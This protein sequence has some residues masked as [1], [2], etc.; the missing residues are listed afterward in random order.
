MNER[1]AEWTFIFTRWIGSRPATSRQRTRLTFSNQNGYSWTNYNP[2][3]NVKIVTRSPV[4]ETRGESKFALVHTTSANKGEKK[5]MTSRKWRTGT[6]EC[7]R[8]YKVSFETDT[9]L[10]QHNHI[11]IKYLRTDF[12]VVSPVVL[13]GVFSL[14][15]SFFFL[16]SLFDGRDKERRIVRR[17]KITRAPER[18]LRGNFMSD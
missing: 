11:S 9:T 2:P 8:I 1:S 6:N 5:A 16:S 14:F 15:P 10:K 17:L 12:R 7:N 18:N 3:R 13:R 4:R